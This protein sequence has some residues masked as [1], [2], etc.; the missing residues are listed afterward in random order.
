MKIAE[1]FCDLHD[2]AALNDAWRRTWQEYSTL[3]THT[4][5]NDTDRASQ[6]VSGRRG[7]D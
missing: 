6:T 3:D 4:T 7:K 5:Q 1:G 2:E